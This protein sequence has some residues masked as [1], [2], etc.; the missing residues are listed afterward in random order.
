M[1]MTIREWKFSIYSSCDKNYDSFVCLLKLKMILGVFL[2]GGRR[3]LLS[4]NATKTQVVDYSSAAPTDIKGTFM[5]MRKP[6]YK[7]LSMRK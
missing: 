3:W 6:V 7:F 1:Q 2:T 4:F 5:Q